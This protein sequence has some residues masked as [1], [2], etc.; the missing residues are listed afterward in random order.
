M[1][2]TRLLNFTITLIII[3]FSAVLISA[4]NE[5]KKDPEYLRDI[6]EKLVKCLF[7]NQCTKP[8]MEQRKS[9]EIERVIEQRIVKYGKYKYFMAEK[10]IVNDEYASVYFRYKQEKLKGVVRVNVDYDAEP[11]YQIE[12][13]E[14]LADKKSIPENA[15]AFV[16]SSQKVMFTFPEKRS[17]DTYGFKTVNNNKKSSKSGNKKQGV[18]SLEWNCNENKK[19]CVYFSEVKG[20]GYSKA[21]EKFI[22]KCSYTVEDLIPGKKYYFVLTEITDDVLPI[23]SP[24]SKEISGKA[25]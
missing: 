22:D 25:Y 18:V 21:N 19:Y 5:S 8:A 24:F 2:K 1:R 3:F 12:S 11:W 13:L 6:G 10:Y 4:A 20:R 9:E 14:F 23:E 16:T 17:K 7:F 15:S